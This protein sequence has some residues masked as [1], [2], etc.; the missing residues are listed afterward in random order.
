MTEDDALKLG[1]DIESDCVCLPRKL[2]LRKS[3][4]KKVRKIGGNPIKENKS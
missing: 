2:C 1:I 4:T 3:W